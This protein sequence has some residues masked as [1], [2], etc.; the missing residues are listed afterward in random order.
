MRRL[1]F[2][3]LLLTTAMP[4]LGACSASLDAHEPVLPPPSA[5]PAS[6]AAPTL[7]GSAE[8]H[9]L[10][11]INA[12]RA[13]LG[14]APVTLDP[15]LSA[16]A[17]EGSRAQMRERRAHGNFRRA[18]RSGALYR[19]HGFAGH[20]CENQ[21][22]NH[23]WTPMASVQA[24]IDDIL[25]AMW[26]EGPGGGHYDNMADRRAKRVGIGLV[27]TADGRLYLTNDFSE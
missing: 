18:A 11:A 7:A 19:V 25:A 17:L 2:A 14:L 5:A 6:P 22:D 10:R 4:L 15:Q 1:L 9:N 3:L 20:A 26:R 16:F 24:Q 27:S 12:Y 21:G 13:R 8:E 23:G